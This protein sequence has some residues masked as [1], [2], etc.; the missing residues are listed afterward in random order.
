MG[1]RRHSGKAIVFYWATS[2]GALFK[3]KPE[4]PDGPEVVPQGVT[5]DQGRDVLQI[6]L[7]PRGR[8]LYYQPK[9][10]PSP[11]V[12][13]DVMTGEKKALAFLQ[14]YY[15]EKYGYWLGSEV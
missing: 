4:G 1:A 13:V 3:F 6:A 8:Y 12:Q 15:F 7:S 9:G 10:Y 2:N 5:W 11:L 14:D